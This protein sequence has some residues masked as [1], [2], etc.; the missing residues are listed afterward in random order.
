MDDWALCDSSGVVMSGRTE[1]EV[2]HLL[3]ANE[4]D[5]QVGVYALNRAG[6][7]IESSDGP[8]IPAG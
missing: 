2:R 1:A 4:D 5:G 6:D 7:R 3:K 8:I